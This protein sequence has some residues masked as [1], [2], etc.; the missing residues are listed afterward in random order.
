MIL[1]EHFFLFLFLSLFRLFRQDSEI[2][3]GH[4]LCYFCSFPVTMSGTESCLVLSLLHLVVLGPPSF[5]HL[6]FDWGLLNGLAG[7][8]LE[9]WVSSHPFSSPD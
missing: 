5:L 3:R 4:D 6:L 1:N 2:D 8:R 9:M 7:A